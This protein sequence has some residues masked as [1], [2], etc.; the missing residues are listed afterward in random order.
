V[1]TKFS[2]E[3]AALTGL[4]LLFT[5]LG[6]GGAKTSRYVR[7]FSE[8]K[9]A[10]F[11][12]LIL[13]QLVDPLNTLRNS[14]ADRW[15]VI[16]TDLS[17]TGTHLT[18]AA[19]DYLAQDQRNG[20]QIANAGGGKSSGGTAAPSQPV[21]IGVA[22]ELSLSPPPNQEVDTRSIA[23][24]AADWLADCN[25][26]IK[27]LTGWDPVGQVL[28]EVAGNWM[29][30]KTIGAAYDSGA[31]ALDTVGRD[32]ARGTGAV[33]PHWDGH[34]SAT[35]N[36]YSS[37]LTRGIEWESSVGRLINR[38]L[39]MVADDLNKA[40]I[41]AVDILVKG[42]SKIVKVD[43]FVGLLKMAARF[44]PY[45]GQ[46]ATAGQIIQL[47]KEVH[48]QVMPLIGEIKRGVEAFMAFLK[49]VQ[50]PMGAAQDKAQQS[51]D[52][53]LAPYREK[54]EKGKQAGQDL[55]DVATA[56]QIDRVTGQPKVAWD[57]GDRGKMRDDE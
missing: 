7:R 31:N 28:H 12:G 55:S 48:D 1:V 47:I 11:S 20:A 21:S 5:D 16:G 36:E 22:T 53:K 2:V 45:A 18:S 49:V 52:D 13:P 32:A 56:V 9:A 33:D 46:A 26:A 41:L 14:T 24:A 15:Q 30:L 4:G 25:D 6:A 23:E 29:A 51:V 39:I 38:G 27:S 50:D 43:S 44:V 35:F 40:A 37:Q 8:P 57:V 19:W 42:L 17:T 10:D 34:A 3:P 54:L